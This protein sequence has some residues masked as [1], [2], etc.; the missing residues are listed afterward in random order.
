[1]SDD[2]KLGVSVV[3]KSDD[4]WFVSYY[5]EAT[6]WH[7]DGD[8]L[9]VTKKSDQGYEYVAQFRVEVWRS[10]ELGKLEFPPDGE[11]ANV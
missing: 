11:K 8:T 9:I 4:H 10:V 5:A 7:S 1:M 2:Q 6:G 3:W